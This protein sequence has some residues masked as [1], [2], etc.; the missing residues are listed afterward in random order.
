MNTKQVKEWAAKSL[1]Q[2][3]SIYVPEEN[4]H[5]YAV[6]VIHGDASAAI[7]FIGREVK[8]NLY[9]AFVWERGKEVFLQEYEN[10][11]IGISCGKF[12]RD[13]YTYLQG[14]FDGYLQQAELLRVI[15]YALAKGNKNA[16][17]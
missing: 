15:V 4:A 14:L 5:I 7:A 2:G 13:K 8:S 12:L 9:H 6:E 10:T 16:P 11:G 3:T 1:E 17:N